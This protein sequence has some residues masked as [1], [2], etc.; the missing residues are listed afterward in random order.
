M[1]SGIDGELLL[2]FRVLDFTAL[3]TFLVPDVAL[4]LDRRNLDRTKVLCGQIAQGDAKGF[5]EDCDA[6]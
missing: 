2:P 5:K 3:D 1:L 6:G 4:P